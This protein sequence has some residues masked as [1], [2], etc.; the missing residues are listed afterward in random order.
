MKTT[1]QIKE[2]LEYL[3]FAAEMEFISNEA[4]QQAVESIHNKHENEEIKE[5][6]EKCLFE[7]LP[8]N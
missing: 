7:L 6:A 4:A 8:R 2:N 1:Q 3:I 5:F